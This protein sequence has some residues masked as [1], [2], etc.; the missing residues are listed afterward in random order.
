[1][2]P[3]ALAT[4]LP[5]WRCALAE[6]PGGMLWANAALQEAVD[7]LYALL[8]RCRDSSDVISSPAR[9]SA[10]I[11]NPAPA[12]LP[13]TASPLVWAGARTEAGKAG[14]QDDY[15]AVWDAVEALPARWRAALFA[16]AVQ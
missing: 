16:D 6:S 4:M 3:K 12:A 5:S 2:V 15:G 11:R 1:M 10:P 8:H 13:V 7:L 9:K 14:Q